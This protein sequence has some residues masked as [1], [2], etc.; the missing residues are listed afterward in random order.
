MKL[1]KM[2]N[3]EYYDDYIEEDTSVVER[4]I[5]NTKG[6]KVK[7]IMNIVFAILIIIMVMITVDVISVSRYKVG[8]F[9]AIRT[10]VYKDG[11]TKVY[12]GLGYKV[13]KYHQKQG[14][15][16][17]KIGPWTMPYTVEPTNVSTLDLAIELRNNPEKAYKK[18]G[19]KFLRIEGKIEKINIESKVIT[20]KYNDPDNKYD[21]EVVCN[22][23]K[24]NN[25]NEK[26]TEN[27]EITVIGTVYDFKIKTK[28]NPNQLYVDNCFAE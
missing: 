17:T 3:K 22:M 27:Q 13:I 6:N 1:F 23:E 21:L 18:F 20:L 16:D 15:R 26:L 24:M 9:F 2:K 4:S 25:S 10:N 28:K 14:R 12:Y 11:G 19:N 5:K 8:P 7:K